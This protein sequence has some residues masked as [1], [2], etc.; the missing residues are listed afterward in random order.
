MNDGDHFATKDDLRDL[1]RRMDDKL[2]G[3][4]E[5]VQAVADLRETVDGL[6]ETMR[7][8]IEAQRFVVTLH[9]FFKWLGVPFVALFAF[10]VWLF[11]NT[12]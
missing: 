7:P 3:V 8:T 2:K 10:I 9:S 12:P 1:E 11:K 5:L 4:S 6:I